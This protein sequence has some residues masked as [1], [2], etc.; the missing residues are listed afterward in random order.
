MQD[1]A[2][3]AIDRD[4]IPGR[5]DAEASTCPLARLS[6]MKGGGSTTML[7][8]LVGI[9]AADR[10]PEPKLIIV[11]GEREGHPK[12]QR[13]GAALAPA[14]TTRESASG[15]RHR[16]ERIAVDLAYDRRMQRRRYRDRIAV[17]AE[18][19]GRCDRH[20]DVAEAEARGDRHGASRC[21]ASNRPILSLSRTFDHDTSR[22]R[23]TSSPSSAANPLST[24]TM[25]AA[26]STSGMKPM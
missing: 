26:A 12:G 21:A 15:G 10:H 13:L 9:D 5:A 25:R 18:I 11:G 7:D 6:A 19:E 22:T 17:E 1:M 2:D 8:I 16:I 14:A 3:A 20:L 24:A 4:R 23:L